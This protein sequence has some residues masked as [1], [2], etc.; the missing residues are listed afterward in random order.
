MS[1]V[2]FYSEQSMDI[3][4]NYVGNIVRLKYNVANT[5][6]SNFSTL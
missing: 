3:F 2:C 1:Y 4:K 5:T 6:R